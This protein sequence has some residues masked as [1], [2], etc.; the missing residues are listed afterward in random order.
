M[1]GFYF[2]LLRDLRFG[3]SNIVA[4]SNLIEDPSL[5]V[6]IKELSPFVEKIPLSTS[7]VDLL[8]SLIIL[9]FGEP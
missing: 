4:P 5:L 9:L 8:L 7:T 2:V 6:Y 1:F 3:E